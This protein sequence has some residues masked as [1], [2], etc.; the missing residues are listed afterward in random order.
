[1]LTGGGDWLAADDCEIRSHPKGVMAHSPGA[2]SIA[3]GFL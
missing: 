1:M 2:G 3:K